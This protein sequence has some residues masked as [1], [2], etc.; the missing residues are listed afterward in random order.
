MT[1]PLSNEGKLELAGKVG[2]DLVQHF[3]KKKYYAKAMINAAARRQGIAAGSMFWDYALH[4]SAATFEE[5]PKASRRQLYYVLPPAQRAVVGQFLQLYLH[6]QPD[7][8]EP[9]GVSN[10]L[11]NIEFWPNS[12]L[13]SA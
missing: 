11:R 13:P 10:F 7:E 2:N 4:T 12:S 1:H 6:Y 5:I 3:G 8:F 9:D